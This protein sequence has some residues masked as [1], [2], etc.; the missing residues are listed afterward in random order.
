L[1]L[2]GTHAYIFWSLEHRAGM[3]AGA[4]EVFMAAAPLAGGEASPPGRVALPSDPTPA[5]QSVAGAYGYRHLS[6]LPPGGER[7][8]SDYLLLPSPLATQGDELPV[9]VSARMQYRRGS[10]VQP[11][12]AVYRQGELWAYQAPARAG[13][14]ALDG[15]LQAD[16]QG[17]LHLAW[18][19]FV[20][21]GQYDLFYATTAAGPR[22]AIDR[23]TPHDLTLSAL[24]FLWGVL[25]GLSLVPFVIFMVVPALLWV[26]IVYIFGSDDTLTEGSIRLALAFAVLLYLGAKLLLFSAVLSSPPLAGAIP[27]SLLSVWVWAFPLLIALAALAAVVLYTRRS[28]R[29]TLLWGFIWFVAVDFFLSIALYGPSFFAR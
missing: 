11:V 17:N 26:G 18:T 2:D 8:A 5:Y 13:G 19:D 1:G 14:L 16:A 23:L 21:Y 28:S 29:P 9:A 12:V 22:Q 15:V 7:Y 27:A 4:A 20:K 6:L 10:E 24:D 3:A 25:S